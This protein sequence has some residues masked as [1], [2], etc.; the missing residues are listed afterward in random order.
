[1]NLRLVARQ[2]AIICLLIGGTMV[3]SLLWAFPRFGRRNHLPELEPRDF[4][5]GGFIALLVSIVICIGVGVV[6]L[7]LG[8]HAQGNL[9]RKE[10]MAV[11]GLSWVLATFL[12]ALP[13]RFGGCVR[14]AAIR[15]SGPSQLPLTHEFDR[16][17]W[18][19]WNQQPVLSEKQRVGVQALLEAGRDGLTADQLSGDPNFA[20]VPTA[21]RELAE[22]SPAWQRVLVVPEG[23]GSTPGAQNRFQVKWVKMTFV[24]ALFESQSGFST[25]GATVIS[26]LEDPRLV[27]HCILFWRSSTHF[28]GGLGI[29]VL[30]VAILG[31]GSAGKA[32]MR[33]EMPGPSKEGTQMR[34]QHTAQ[35]FAAIYCGLTALLAILLKIEG[36][37][38]FDAFCHSFGTMA[39]G[40]FSTYDDSIGHFGWA[41]IDFTIIVFMILAGTNFALLYALCCFRP[42]RLFSNVEWRTYMVLITLVTLMVVFF[43]MAHRDFDNTPSAIQHG[44]FQVVA[45]VTTTGFGTND[46]DAWNNVGRALLLLLMFWSGCPEVGSGEEEAEEIW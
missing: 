7:Y 30:F 3:F 34:M 2:L 35:I 24:D 9:Y 37:S 36:L 22:S 18:Q 6:L 31:Q 17:G 41:W 44:L 26:K 42:G 14:S 39:T 38:W 29:I 25:T 13:Y 45:I 32:L 27:P 33:A 1:M 20:D 43:G 12:G 5:T 11:V 19:Q 21:L 40:G 8:R 23:N 15:L 16:F 10:A 46:F 4:E 28:L